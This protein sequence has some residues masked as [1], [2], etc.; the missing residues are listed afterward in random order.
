MDHDT[1]LIT[2][3]LDESGSMSHIRRAT[4]EGFNAYRQEQ[5]AHGGE[6][7][8]TLTTFNQDVNTRFSALPGCRVPRLGREYSPHGC[9]ALYDAI[10]ASIVKTRAQLSELGGERPADI[11]VVILTDGME[12][13][14]RE[15]TRAQVFELIT[16]AENAG[17]QFIFLGAN[18]DSWE[19][20]QN[21]GIRR[22]AVVDWSPDARSHAHAIEEASSAT[23]DFRT[24]G[25]PLSYY[26]DRRES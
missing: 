19:V 12:N 17:W 22:G 20:S 24:H 15:W 5:I 4:R 1:A 8:W 26:R 3:I 25:L 21:L 9:T 2:F 18:Q 13:A 23:C 16:E 7:W 14:S 10:G 6:T 11:I